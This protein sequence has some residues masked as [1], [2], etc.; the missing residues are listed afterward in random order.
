MLFS[1]MVKEE[2]KA[3][4]LPLSRW[5]NLVSD[6]ATTCVDN[7]LFEIKGD[8]RR[9]L[10]GIRKQPP[11]KDCLYPFGSLNQKNIWSQDMIA[12]I[13]KRET[14]L[15]VVPIKQFAFYEKLYSETE[16]PKIKKGLHNN[17]I[18]YLTRIV[19]GKLKLD[20]THSGF[21]WIESLDEL[22]LPPYTKM[23]IQDSGIFTKPIEELMGKLPERLDAPI[24][25]VARKLDYRGIDFSQYA[26]KE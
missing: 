17:C 24:N 15:K 14:G 9:V 20:A 8:K 26:I 13:V 12:P 1:D 5:I 6:G 3:P 19:E 16:H 4:R 10:L 21:R 2:F 22:P 23:I 18:G 11:G 7:V 25:V